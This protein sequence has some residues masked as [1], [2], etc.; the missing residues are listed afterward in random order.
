MLVTTANEKMVRVSP[1]VPS[2]SHLLAVGAARADSTAPSP[3]CPLPRRRHLQVF[4]GM[5]S[6]WLAIDFTDRAQ[7]GGGMPK[8]AVLR[9]REK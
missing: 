9:D 1:L 7:S 5:F 2:R 6:T 3:S 4:F 8:M